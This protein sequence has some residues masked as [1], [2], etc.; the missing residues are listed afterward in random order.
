MDF[1]EVSFAPVKRNIVRLLLKDLEEAGE[2]AGVDF[3][4]PLPRNFDKSQGR[5]DAVGSDLIP[6]VRGGQVGGDISVGPGS[7]SA[8]KATGVVLVTKV[9]VWIVP[10]KCKFGNEKRLGPEE[11]P[12]LYHIW[13]P[14]IIESYG[15]NRRTGGITNLDGPGTIHP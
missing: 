9:Q 8:T 1:N 7:G 13:Y 4:Q 15:L 3:I 12:V 5:A 2:V 10:S 6:P 14:M 11:F